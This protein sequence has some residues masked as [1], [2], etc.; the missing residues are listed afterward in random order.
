MAH[1]RPIDMARLIICAIA[2]R[3]LGSAPQSVAA[4]SNLSASN[5]AVLIDLLEGWFSGA[6]PCAVRAA[7]FQISPEPAVTLIAADGNHHNFGPDRSRDATARNV[8]VSG[9]ALYAIA[10][11]FR[12]ATPEAANEQVAVA[13]LAAVLH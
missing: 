9:D 5:G 13:K 12:G 1:L 8:I 2:D 4:Y 11:E 6:V 3:G 7:I 10:L